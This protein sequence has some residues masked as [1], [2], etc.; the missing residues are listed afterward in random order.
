MANL[1]KSKTD[2]QFL[3][4][5]SMSDGWI[6][7]SGATCH[8]AGSKKRFTEFNAIHRETIF[9]ANGQRAATAGKGTIHVNFVIESVKIENFLKVPSIRRNLISVK[10]LAD[11]G[12]TVQFGDRNCEISLNQS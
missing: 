10:R 8:I 12:Y 2:D 6:L 3:F 5:T 11:K 4:V 1:T 9:V 7:D